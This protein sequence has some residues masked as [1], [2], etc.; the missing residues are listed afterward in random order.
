MNALQRAMFEVDRFAHLQEQ[1]TAQLRPFYDV[2]SQFQY[3]V[4]W[5]NQLHWTME[6][7]RQLER[8]L[9]AH[10][11]WLSTWDYRARQWAKLLEA[12]AQAMVPPARKL[13]GLGWTVPMWAEPKLVFD[14]LNMEPQ[15]IEELF[16]SAYRENDRAQFRTLCDGLANRAIL[17]PWRLLLDDCRCD[18]VEGRFRVVVP[19]L[20]LILEGLLVA[21]RPTARRAKPVSIAL[22]HQRESEM[23]NAAVWASVVAF[24][25]VVFKGHSFAGPR[26]PVINRHRVYHGR[27]AA[28]WGEAECLRLFQAVDTISCMCEP[29]HKDGTDEAA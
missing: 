23:L 27:D 4:V 1:I 26:P 25:S 12:N 7:A 17:A 29:A 5:A 24:L 6:P 22:E 16:L 10:Q 2:A 20:L 14:V 11:D 21:S 15:A 8:V 13:G 19:G 28:T 18:F 3:N 9:H